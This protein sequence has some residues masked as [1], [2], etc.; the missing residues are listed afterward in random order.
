[1]ALLTI[2][3]TPRKG[4]NVSDVE[5]Q[6]NSALKNVPGVSFAWSAATGEFRVDY[7]DDINF[8]ELS[9]RLRKCM[10]LNKNSVRKKRQ[11]S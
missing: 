8:K 2:I 1:M 6:I 10:G 9:D 5:S 4:E 3:V 7:S 11:V